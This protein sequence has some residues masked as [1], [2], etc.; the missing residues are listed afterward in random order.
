MGCENCD[1]SPA[2]RE[3]AYEAAK[4]KAKEYAKAKQKNVYTYF[5]PVQGWQWV[6]E[7]HAAG[8]LVRELISYS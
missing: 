2:G 6:E 3:R 1:D 7:E 5:D 4:I 8:Y